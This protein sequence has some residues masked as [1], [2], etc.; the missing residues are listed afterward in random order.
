[1]TR[2][3]RPQQRYDHR[4]RNLVR[5]TGDLTLATDLG[6]P[7]STARGWLHRGPT[8]VVSLDG[9]PRSEV[10][11]HQEIRQLR[12]RVQKLRALLRL[13]LTLLDGTELSPRTLRTLL[14]EL[15]SSA[16]RRPASSLNT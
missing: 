3:A 11:L 2:R 9:T 15:S 14:R 1:M 12:R 16:Q 4:L 8:V 13:V 5:R 6:V 7:R 10:D